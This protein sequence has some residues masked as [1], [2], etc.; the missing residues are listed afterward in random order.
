MSEKS[1]VAVTATLAG[2]VAFGIIHAGSA[3]AQSANKLLGAL[4]IVLVAIGFVALLTVV[5]IGAS[6]C[7][8]LELEQRRER[9]RLE[10]RRRESERER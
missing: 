10:A 6:E 5:T 4:G 9:E 1:K 8:R 7:E 3:L 2:A